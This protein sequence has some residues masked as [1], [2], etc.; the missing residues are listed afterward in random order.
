MDH[1]VGPKSEQLLAEA[2]AGRRDS[3]GALLERHRVYLR[4][5]AGAKIDPHL[6]AQANPSDLVQE[7]FLLASRHFDQFRGT[8]AGEWLHWLRCILRRCLSRFVRKH[9][10]TRK[11]NAYREVSLQ[12][13]G[14]SSVAAYGAGR[15]EVPDPGSSP[16]A[17]AQRRELADLVAERLAHLSPA[18]RDVL[19]LRNLMGL[20]FEEVARRMQRSA[21]AVRVLW[22]RA[23]DQLRRQRFSEDWL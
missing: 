17:R 12:G 13:E 1:S 19:V 2:R 4:M 8:G 22:L 5:L 23:L 16:S 14:M 6:R 21:G 3:L 7:T 18:H 15:P 10:Y 11:R 9:V 20:P